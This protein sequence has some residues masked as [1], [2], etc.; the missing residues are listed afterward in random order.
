MAK[1]NLVSTILWR[2]S[3]QNIK[4][5]QVRPIYENAPKVEKNNEN[6]PALEM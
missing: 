6:T 5:R 4:I 1:Q 3:L 2:Q